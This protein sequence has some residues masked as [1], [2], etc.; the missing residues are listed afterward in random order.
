M[1]IAVALS[2]ACVAIGAAFFAVALLR[3]CGHPLLALLA[4]VPGFYWLVIGRPHPEMLTPWSYVNGMESP[5]SI[6]FFG[7]LCW[8]VLARDALGRGS[9]AGLLAVSA[10]LAGVLLSRLD[11]V[12]LVA[13]VVLWGGWRAAERRVAR[14]AWLALVPTL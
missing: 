10:A 13:L 5:L 9:R 3:V 12:F 4:T 2:A 11:D 14:A 1:G 7:V 8:L 6:L